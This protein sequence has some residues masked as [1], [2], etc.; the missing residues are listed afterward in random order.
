MV[1]NNYERLNQASTQAFDSLK[2]ENLKQQE[3]LALQA[4]GPNSTMMKTGKSLGKNNTLTTSTHWST[5]PS[6]INVN[7]HFLG[8][9]AI[10][11]NF[12]KVLRIASSKNR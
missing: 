3:M 6:S 4:E 11:R 8:T 10:E 12:E 2:A 7:H 9:D 1:Q 5:H